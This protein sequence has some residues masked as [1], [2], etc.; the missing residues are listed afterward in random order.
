MMVASVA[1][2]LMVGRISDRL[3]RKWTAMATYTLTALATWS[4][5]FAGKSMVYLMLLVCFLH[6]NLFS[7]VKEKS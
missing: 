7:I 5:F 2:P 6:L 3:G 4:L 1:G